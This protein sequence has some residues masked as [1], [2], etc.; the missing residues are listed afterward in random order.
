MMPGIGAC[1]AGDQEVAMPAPTTT[2][3]PSTVQPTA[4][5][6]P[7]F[8]ALRRSAQREVDLIDRYD[9]VLGACRTVPPELACA[10]AD[11]HRRVEELRRSGVPTPGRPRPWR[12]LLHLCLGTTCRLHLL[13]PVGLLLAA[14]RRQLAAYESDNELP[15]GMRTRAVLDQQAVVLAIQCLATRSALRAIFPPRKAKT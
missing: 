1:C 2:F 10:A 6:L 4:A 9:H 12:T 11:H 8:E 5:I 14:E 13:D 3:F 15:T 7:K